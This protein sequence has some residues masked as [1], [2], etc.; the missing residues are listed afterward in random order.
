MNVCNN[1]SA[2]RIVGLEL[3]G[4]NTK[5]DDRNILAQVVIQMLLHLHD[6]CEITTSHKS[7]ELFLTRLNKRRI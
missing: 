1:E 2:D 7:A 6:N 4:E 5:M 3:M